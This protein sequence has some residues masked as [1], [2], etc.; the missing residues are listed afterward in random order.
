M[1]CDSCDTLV[2]TVVH[3]FPFL[4]PSSSPPITTRFLPSFST[5]HCFLSFIPHLCNPASCNRYVSDLETHININQ[6]QHTTKIHQVTPRLSSRDTKS[7]GTVKADA[8]DR[9]RTARLHKPQRR[10][11]QGGAGDVC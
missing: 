5:F 3:D 11:Y 9:E 2:V 10:S 1:T 4:Y 7:R 6:M 8:Y